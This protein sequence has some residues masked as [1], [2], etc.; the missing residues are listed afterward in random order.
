MT[1][2]WGL[3]L[4]LVGFAEN[5]KRSKKSRALGMTKRKDR[6][7]ERAVAGR[8]GGCWKKGWL[9]DERAVAEPRHCLNPIWAADDLH[10][11]RIYSAKRASKQ[12]TS[13]IL[14]SQLLR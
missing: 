11:T 4:Q 5:T 6:G 1:T 2:L 9:L 10:A 7:K 12:S 13:Y 14:K 3:E 8:K